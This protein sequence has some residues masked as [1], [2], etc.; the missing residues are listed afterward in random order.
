MKKITIIA[1]LSMLLL[2]CCNQ[3]KVYEHY[4]DIKG[5]IWNRF[6]VIEFDFN[7][8]NPSTPY[9]FYVAFRYMEQLP[10]KSMTIDFTFY[11]PSGETRSSEHRIDFKDKDGNLL[12][13]G[14][15]DLWDVEKLLWKGFTFTEPGT[16]KVEISSKMSY[17]DIPGIMQVGLI[18]KRGS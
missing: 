2:T 1:L 6:N 12:G 10:L 15:G 17:S 11:T 3:R 8:E 16:C 14:M 9:D 13:H 7:I 18:V 4:E 5:N